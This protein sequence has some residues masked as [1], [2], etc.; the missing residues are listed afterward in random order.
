[1]QLNDGIFYGNTLHQQALEHFN[2][3]LTEYEP[4]DEL[5]RHYHE[6][7]YLSLLLAGNYIEQAHRTDNMIASGYSIFR[8]EAHEHANKFD[9]QPGKCFNVE[10]KSNAM[11]LFGHHIKDHQSIILKRSFLEL[12]LL[13]QRFR[14]SYHTDAL[15]ILSFE[16]ISHLFENSD[17]HRYGR[18]LWIKNIVEWVNDTP[19]EHFTI[20]TIAAQA[21][22]HPIYMLRK[23][24]EKTGVRLSDYINRTR[25]EKAANTIIAG[26]ENLTQI[27]YT[28]GF[29]D[30]SHFS[31]SFKAYFGASPR[32]FK[33]YLKG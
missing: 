7:P 33:K 3:T 31:R 13:Y 24:K 15:D 23:F 18:A 32:N 19:E 28:S 16:V 21:N 27:A 12:F 11:Q 25:L 6:N 26:Q 8:A 2:L 5:P 9:R 4:G 10:L 30:Q 1:M 20:E 17:P 22:V 29:Y 14:E